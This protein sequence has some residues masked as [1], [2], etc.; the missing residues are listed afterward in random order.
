[1][2]TLNEILQDDITR[3][4]EGVIKADDDRRIAQEIREYVV[5]AEISRLL[6]GFFE[7]YAE[8]IKRQKQRGRDIYPFN[9]VWISGYFGSGKSHLLKIL[10]YLLSSNAEP[11]L[12][13]VF[14]AK[15]EDTWLKGAVEEAFRTPSLSVLFNIDQKTDTDTSKEDHPILLVFEK[16]FNHAVGYCDE[17]PVVADFERDLD[18]RGEYEEFKKHF[19]QTTGTAWEKRRIGV[20]TMDRSLFAAAWAT[21]KNVPEQDAS[22]L[23]DR[24]ESSRS[25]SADKLARRIKT[26]LD[27]PSSRSSTDPANV[28][29]TRINFFVDEVGQFVAG[30][31]A[32]M[33]NLQ[34][35]A[36][37]FATVC[38]NRVWVFVTSQEDID[39]V[40][41]DATQEQR[42]DFSRI[43]ARFHFRLPLTSSNVAEVIQKRLLA[44]TD[45][46]HTRLSQ[47]YQEQADHLQTVFH[48]GQGVKEIRFR[49]VDDFV[50]SYPFLAY[51]YYYLQSALKGLSSH[52]AFTGRHVSRGERSML[53]VFQ[54]VGKQMANMPLIRFATFDQMFDGIRQTLQ[55][56]LL[57]QVDTAEQHLDNPLAIR[58]IKALLMLKYV[59]DFT[60]TAEHLTTLM[61]E[62]LDQDRGTLRTAVHEALDALEYQS[63]IQRNGDEYEYL[64]DREKDIEIAIKNTTVEYTEMRRFIGEVVI[65]RIL[66]TNKLTYEQ[67]DQPYAFSVFIDGEQFR[68]A[69]GSAAGGLIMRIAT[70]LHPNA[71]DIQ[72][73]LNQSMGRKELLVVLDVPRHADNDLRLFHQT[74]T[75]LN[76]SVRTDD[77]QQTRILDEKRARNAARERTLRE[78]LVPGLIETSAL[79]VGDRSLDIAI[80]D[81]RER[82][83]AAFQELVRVSFPNLRM[84]S[85]RYS[86]KGLQKILFPE[87]GDAVFSADAVGMGDD[88]AETQG[89]LQRQ[90][91]DAKNTTVASIKDE[92]SGGQYGWPEWAVL[93]VVAK[94][95]ARDAVELVEGTRI[96]DKRDVWDRLVKAHGHENVRVRL[97]QPIDTGTVTTLARFFQDFFHRSPGA[98]GGKELMIEVKET[99][100]ELR[101][102]LSQLIQRQADYPFLGQLEPVLKRYDALGAMEIRTLAET[103]VLE[104]ESLVM[105]K[106]ELVDKAIQFMKGPGKE[107]YDRIRLYLQGNRD[108][109]SALGRVDALGKL[110]GFLESPSPW[111]GNATKTAQDLYSDVAGNIA[112][113]MKEAKEAART[114]IEA[115]AGTLKKNESLGRLSKDQQKTVLR[116]VTDDLPR[117]VTDTSSLATLENITEIQI[118][119]TVQNIREEI[120][121]RANPEQKVQYAGAG[122]KKITF[123][124]PELVTVEDVDAYADEL[125]RRWRAL[126]QNG[127]RIGL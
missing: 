52:N 102:D 88:E 32:R 92:F 41:G 85:G 65:S 100:Q 115:A 67:N 54:G 14:L 30:N 63:Y 126:V 93:G 79:Y 62:S 5:T 119:Q 80:K 9:G 31:R 18:E 112:S 15:I 74:K 60:P 35:V 26:W 36:E 56:G 118:P 50:L 68:A 116:P 69:A 81:P 1:M 12:R 13:E 40:I 121:K 29:P 82:L 34:T 21:F 24:Y 123:A 94:L 7:G 127:K 8:A 53:E 48:F 19:Q 10:S 99:L 49:D 76:H 95:Y 58:L 98:S 90:E 27:R 120:Q 47:F 20:I 101:S 114:A 109:F 42:E 122:E 70:H 16:V 23:L 96:L 39:A 111:A 61:V 57:Q 107:T 75:F 4:I 117:R 3:E 6:R 72:T 43:T 84:L 83:T 45:D 38:E 124:K 103:I 55:S 37:T 2:P 59:E 51:Q 17:D 113:R 89:F 110:E 44:K 28:H 87:D 25:L 46:G 104:E 105:E 125:R 22:D 64:T 71:G 66:K 86:E 91:K 108:N 78:D 33:L 73:L 11:Q 77:P 97:A 106:Y